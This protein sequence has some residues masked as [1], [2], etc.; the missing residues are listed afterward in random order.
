M[1][2]KEAT[3]NKGGRP[4]SVVADAKILKTVLGLGKIQATSKECAAVLGISE[5]T[6]IN[7]KRNNP[8]VAEAY[9]KGVGHGQVS[10][11][12]RQYRAA[13]RGNTT[14]MIWLGKQYLD[15]KDKKDIARTEA[16]SAQDARKKL[17][18]IIERYQKHPELDA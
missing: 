2:K 18:D 1:T 5:P 7:F 8:E 11:R 13:M 4:F 3:K 12:R 6:W 15:Q 17:M 16:V 9:T 10:L 14:M